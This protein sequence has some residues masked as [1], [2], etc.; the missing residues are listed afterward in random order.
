MVLDF[1]KRLICGLPDEV[2]ANEHVRQAYLGLEDNE[3]LKE[4]V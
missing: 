4:V 1:G 2:M 3:Q